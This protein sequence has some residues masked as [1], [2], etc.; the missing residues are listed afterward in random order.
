VAEGVAQE[1]ECLLSK[2]EA[3]ISN[4]SSGEREREREREEGREGGKEGEMEIRSKV[5]KCSNV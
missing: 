1:V 5:Q 2:R 3:L 4:P